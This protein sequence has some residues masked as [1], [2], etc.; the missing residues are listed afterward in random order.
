MAT[1]PNESQIEA[2]IKTDAPIQAWLK[3]HADLF[4]SGGPGG[5]TP[6]RVFGLMSAFSELPPA[7]QALMRAIPPD[8]GYDPQ[9]QT[10]QHTGLGPGEQKLLIMGGLALTGGAMAG[11]I[12][13]IAGVGST[14]AAAGATA[15]ESGTVA[16]GT[17]AFDESGNWVPDAG[18][19]ATVPGVDASSGGG[20]GGLG[21]LA[22][23]ATSGAIPDWLKTVLGIA[24]PIAGGIGE[25]LLTQHRNSFSGT[26][27]DPVKLLGDTGPMMD[28]FRSKLTAQMATPPQFSADT[29]PQQPPVFSGPGLPGPI[30]LS[31]Q[32]SGVRRKPLSSPQDTQATGDDAARATK[33]LSILGY[34]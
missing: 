19:S 23:G 26:S 2:Q 11:A 3:K 13:G 7:E 6:D 1:F 34:G 15:A 25:G 18:T 10:I 31:G 29:T 16:G 27:S 17:G 14:P 28:D 22:T 12:P 9:T 32:A 24:G 20:A 5:N 4:T 21:S 33:A 30:G 8:Y